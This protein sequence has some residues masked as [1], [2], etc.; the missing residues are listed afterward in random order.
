MVPKVADYSSDLPTTAQFESRVIRWSPD[1]KG[2]ALLDR[3]TFC[4]AFEV[5]DSE[6]LDDQ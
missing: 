5:A 2:M 6:T 1:G 4:C 3:D